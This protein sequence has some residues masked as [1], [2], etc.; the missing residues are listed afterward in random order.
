MPWRSATRQLALPRVLNAGESR[1]R[2]LQDIFFFFPHTRPISKQKEHHHQRKAVRMLG[3]RH[4]HSRDDS[5]LIVLSRN[6]G[7]PVVIGGG[8]DLEGGQ[9]RYDGDPHR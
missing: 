9:H 6:Q 8:P 1:K 7:D 2:T 4:L 3:E 5:W